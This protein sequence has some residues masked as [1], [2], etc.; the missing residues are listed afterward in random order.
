MSWK[1]VK[2]K[3]MFKKYSDSFVDNEEWEN[4]AQLKMKQVALEYI[5]NI[6]GIKY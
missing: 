6:G 5:V 4:N 1:S 2:L 3:K